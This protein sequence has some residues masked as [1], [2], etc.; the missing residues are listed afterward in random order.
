MVVLML[1]T[2]LAAGMGAYASVVGLLIVVP[3]AFNAWALCYRDL[4]AREGI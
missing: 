1:A 2:H 4:A 3:V